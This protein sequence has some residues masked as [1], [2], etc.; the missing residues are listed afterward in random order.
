MKIYNK[1]IIE[2]TKEDGFVNLQ[3]KT[4]SNSTESSAFKLGGNIYE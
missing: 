1:Q 2:I 4:I 3:Q